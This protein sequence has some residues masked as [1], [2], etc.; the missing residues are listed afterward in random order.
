MGYRADSEGSLIAT[1]FAMERCEPENQRRLRGP[2]IDLSIAEGAFF[3]WLT[4]EQGLSVV[5]AATCLASLRFVDT[6]SLRESEFDSG[7]AG[8]HHKFSDMP[9]LV[10]VALK[11]HAVDA[12]LFD[13]DDGHAGVTL[14]EPVTID[15]GRRTL[16]IYSPL[17]V[18]W[19]HIL[20]LDL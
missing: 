15:D 19:K 16:P 3:I 6:F 18:P 5:D 14:L 10:K 4:E 11:D 2:G 12:V 17:W 1:E 13:Q 20:D 7:L 8:I 9:A